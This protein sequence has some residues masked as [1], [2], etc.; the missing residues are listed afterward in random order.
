MDLLQDMFEALGQILW[1]LRPDGSVERFNS[2]WTT[3]TGRPARVEGLTW[4]EVFHPDDR[5]RLVQART[6][7]VASRKPYE[8]EARMRRADGVYR[9]HLCRVKPLRREGSIYAWVGMAVDI[10]DVRAAEERQRALVQLGDRLRDLSDTKEI[11]WAGAAVVGQVLGLVRAGFASVEGDLAIIERDWLSSPDERP[12][13]GTY[14]ISDWGT[15]LTPLARGDIVAIADV[16]T[17]LQTA[18]AAESWLEWGIRSV[19]FI[20]VMI[21]RRLAAYMFL[22]NREVRTWTSDEIDFIHS[23]GDRV[24]SAI[25]RSTAERDLRESEAKFQGIANSVDQ[26]IWSSGPDGYPDYYNRRWYQY[27]GLKEGST[28]R[29]AA[30]AFVKPEDQEKALS[31]WHHAVTTGEP[32]Y[33]EHRLRHHSGEYRWVIGR[34]QCVR[35]ENGQIVRWYGS[36]TD[37]DDLKRAAE[38]LRRTSALLR[39]IGNSVPDMIYAKDRNSGVL[40]GNR[41]IQQVV[42]RPIDEILGLS[43]RD[44]ASDLQE[45]ERIIANDRRVMETGDTLDV[46]E[47]FT[48]P[49]GETRYFRSVKAPLR[50]DT[51]S[52][53]G[54]VGITSDMTD[55]RRAEERERLLAR[56][57]DHRAKNLLAVVQSVVQ[58]TRAEDMTSFTAAITGRI[59]SLARAHSLLAA[60]RW[61]GA[62]LKQII[63]EEMAP[64]AGRDAARVRINGPA[65]RLRPEAA[66]ALALVIHELAT[67]AAK[68]GAL[69]VEGGRLDITWATTVGSDEEGW[70]GLRWQERGGPE[71][72]RPSRRGFGSTVMRASIERQLQGTVTLDW[73]PHG[74]VCEL[75]VSAEQ[76]TTAALLKGARTTRGSRLTREEERDVRG[77]RVLVVEDE[78]LI[79]MQIEDVL[80]QAGCTVV[81]PASRIADAFDLLYGEGVDAALLDV[82]V[83]GDRSFALAD[84]LA[85]KGVPF[86]FV[87]GFEANSTVPERFQGV[88]VV[89]K[90]FATTELVDAVDRL[91]RGERRH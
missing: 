26:M 62:E 84:I 49:N 34:A 30:I 2:A 38:E 89:A 4:A 46:D 70:L 43:D 45:A 71:V 88:P 19:A 90:P 83:A 76:L 56:E 39:L 44:W 20:P 87:T 32:Y 54:L 55:R 31:R 80:H 66:Q 68:Y 42:G 40:Y 10:E 18:D 37:V 8:V 85:S 60:S 86:A 17:N 53:I 3:Y 51:G 58:L 33:S 16:A 64:Y 9:R 48:G 41:A 27:T 36:L 47:M 5:Q 67:N 61:E 15:Y 11:A 29:N 24:W 73:D 91:A 12:S 28:D 35:D 23:V 59:Q 69:S 52:I 13:A 50:D 75:A 72:S 77:Q 79:A 82:N 22:H 81:G 1:F 65:I 21:D 57:V 6:A 74:L 25:Q 7:G 63:V 14:R 78:A